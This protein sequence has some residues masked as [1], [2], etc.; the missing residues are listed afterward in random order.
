MTSN[1]DEDASQAGSR[2]V[3]TPVEVPRVNGVLIALTNVPD[4]ESAHEIAEALVRE[5]F[6][7]CVNILSGCT[8]IYRWQQDVETAEEIPLLI[9]TTIDRFAALQARLTELHPYDVPE[10]IA[11]RPDAV[12]PA[13]AGWVITGTRNRRPVR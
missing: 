5:R 6:A 2:P 12:L 3:P 8:S 7:A 1:H 4:E 10:L 11:W 13:Y 9:K